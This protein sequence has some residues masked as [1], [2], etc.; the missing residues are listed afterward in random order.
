M[1]DRDRLLRPGTQVRRRP[2]P[3]K[4][5]GDLN[6]RHRGVPRLVRPTVTSIPATAALSR[7]MT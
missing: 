1:P 4:A 2:P 6:P 5:Y 7:L 3:G